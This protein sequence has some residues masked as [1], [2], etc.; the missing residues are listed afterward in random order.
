[1]SC[2]K[3]LCYEEERMKEFIPTY[4]DAISGVLSGFDRMVFHGT[5]GQIAYPLGLQG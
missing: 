5:L 1:M 2:P 3:T 4:D